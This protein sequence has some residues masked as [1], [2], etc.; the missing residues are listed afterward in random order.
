[1]LTKSD[2]N[3][4]RQV[5]KSETKPEFKKIDN[6]IDKIDKKFDKLFNFLDRDWSKTNK[7]IDYHDQLQGVDTRKIVNPS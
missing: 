3:A 2:L 4:I 5:V 7:R 1:M 6:K